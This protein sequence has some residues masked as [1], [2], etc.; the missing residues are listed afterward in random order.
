M[1]C[2]DIM[3][4]LEELSPKS[5]AEDWDNVGLMVGDPEKE[6][7]TIFLALDATD[8]AIDEAILMGA[9]MIVTHHPLIFKGL[10]SV[11]EDH[12]IGRR[13][14]KLARHNICLYSMHTNF[15]VMGMADAAA[16]ELKLNGREVLAKTFEDDIATEGFGRVGNLPRA[17]TLKDAAEYVRDAFH[18]SMVRV[19]GNPDAPVHRAAVCPG[20]GGSMIE[21]AL[22][23]KAEVYIT[24]DIDHHEGI[25]AVAQGLSIIDAGHYGIEQIFVPYMKDYLRRELPGVAVYTVT[26]KEPCW[27]I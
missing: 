13:I 5:F 7:K 6:V 22:A 1:Q 19:F 17:M 18:V 20:S 24:G 2:Q 9:D 12:F 27:F 4:Q 25:D 16:D 11:S 15:D 10:K 21:D 8:E 3:D 26:P 14:L 23:A